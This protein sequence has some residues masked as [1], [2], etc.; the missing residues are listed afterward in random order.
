MFSKTACFR[1]SFPKISGCQ[2]I[3]YQ[4]SFSL[5][6]RQKQDL[7]HTKCRQTQKRINTNAFLNRFPLRRSCLHVNNVLGSS[8]TQPLFFFFTTVNQKDL[9]KPNVKSISHEVE[10]HKKQNSIPEA[11]ITWDFIRCPLS[12]THSARNGTFI[13]RMSLPSSFA[14]CLV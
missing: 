11:A 13:R 4:F 12:R 10:L 1:R 5:K 3:S 8:K 6:M 14:A 9:R 2:T 7:K